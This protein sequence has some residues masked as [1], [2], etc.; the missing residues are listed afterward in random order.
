MRPALCALLCAALCVASVQAQLP[1]LP[2]SCTT[3]KDIMELMG[4]EDDINA[5]CPAG[6]AACAPAC[7]ETLQ[8]VG[9][10]WDAGMP[11]D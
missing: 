9:G 10:Q 2:A 5:N 11:G 1:P 6:A 3:L 4:S 8:K 7:K